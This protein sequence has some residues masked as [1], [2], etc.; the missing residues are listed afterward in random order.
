M[1]KK[2]QPKICR[3]RDPILS[4]CSGEYFKGDVCHYPTEPE[5]CLGVEYMGEAPKQ[6]YTKTPEP[7]RPLDIFMPKDAPPVLHKPVTKPV[8]DYDPLTEGLQDFNK[9]ITDELHGM[10][11]K[12]TEYDPKTEPQPEQ[13]P[14]PPR[15]PC[16]MCDG[17]KYW[18]R[19]SSY[20]FGKLSPGEWLCAQCHP[21][22]DAPQPELVIYQDLNT[23][24]LVTVRPPEKKIIVP[25]DF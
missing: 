10:G 18:W 21:P 4:I 9:R 12:A 6:V 14:N 3:F 15:L 25:E 7:I 5:K 23:K 11:I 19:K 17:V 16:N 2:K 20:I 1:P 24:Q 13:I 22:I 8:D